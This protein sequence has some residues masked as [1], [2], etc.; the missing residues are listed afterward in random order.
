MKRGC[1]GGE[2]ITVLYEGYPAA[3]RI[4]RMGKAAGDYDDE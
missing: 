4:E 3:W 1:G 2:G